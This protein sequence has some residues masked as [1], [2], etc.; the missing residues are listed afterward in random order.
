M[1]LAGEASV[2]PC[3]TIPLHQGSVPQPFT[4][5]DCETPC[6]LELYNV[7]K[8]EQEAVE[9]FLFFSRFNFT[10]HPG[11]KSTKPDARSCLYASEEVDAPTNTIVPGM[12]VV[13]PLTCGIERI[14]REALQHESKGL[15][16]LQS[17]F[18]QVLKGHRPHSLPVTLVCNGI[19]LQKHLLGADNQG[20]VVACPTCPRSNASHQ[21]PPGIGSG[22]SRPSSHQWTDFPM[23]HT[24]LLYQSHPQLLRR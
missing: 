3:T 8:Q 23:L 24:Y 18:L 9:R 1:Y 17:V 21:P 11:S 5:H 7:S 15:F 13:P 16:I 2:P 10:Y 6:F 12:R 22:G 4:P 14:I 20:F 19:L